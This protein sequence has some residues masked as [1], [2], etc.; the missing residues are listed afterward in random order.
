MNTH[1]YVYLYKHTSATVVD[2][3]ATI[4]PYIRLGIVTVIW[5]P[6]AT[7]L[8]HTP[9]QTTY[10]YQQVCTDMSHPPT[11]TCTAVRNAFFL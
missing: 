3:L 10:D 9:G 7:R 8:A 2:G 1:F 5:V 4:I 11:H 6:D